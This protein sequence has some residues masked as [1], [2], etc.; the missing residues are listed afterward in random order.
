MVLA[1]ILQAVAGAALG[2]AGAA[3]KVLPQGQA[4]RGG[5]GALVCR[6][7]PHPPQHLLC[8]GQDAAARVGK[9]AV[10]VENEGS[11]NGLSRVPGFFFL[12][13]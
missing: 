2:K 6:F 11:H 13:S 7:A 9:R 3:G 4:D 5:E 12:Q 1:I 8:R 10:E